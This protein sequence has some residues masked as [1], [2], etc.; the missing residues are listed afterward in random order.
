MVLEDLEHQVNQ[1]V[2]ETRSHLDGHYHLVDQ[3]HP[4][5]YIKDITSIIYLTVNTALGYVP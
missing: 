5:E 3:V 2:Q 1:V 4:K